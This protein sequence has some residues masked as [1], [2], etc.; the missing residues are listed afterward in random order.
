MPAAAG[1]PNIHPH[2][3]SAPDDMARWDKDVDRFNDDLLTLEKF[4]LDSAN[5]DLS[6]N[7]EMD[8]GFSYYGTQGTL[9]HRRMAD[10][11]RDRKSLRVQQTYRSIL[12]PSQIAIDV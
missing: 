7:E 5:G 11:Y 2:S 1:G 9:I 3:F 4:F 6:E 12:R 8:R 10:G